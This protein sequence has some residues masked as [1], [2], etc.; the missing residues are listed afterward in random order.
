MLTNFDIYG[1]AA[2]QY[3]AVVEQF[4]ETANSG[5]DMVVTFTDGAADQPMISGI[6]V[7]APLHAPRCLRPRPV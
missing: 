1:T 4:N 6:E 2:A 5:G 7:L 3:T